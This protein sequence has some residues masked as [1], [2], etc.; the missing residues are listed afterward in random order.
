VRFLPSQ[1]HVEHGVTRRALAWQPRSVVALYVV[2]ASL[3]ILVSDRVL[4]VSVGNAGLAEAIASAKGLAF[5]A[6]TAV[7]L[8]LL[9]RRLGR[10]T[11]TR[12]VLPTTMF[13]SAGFGIAIA[14]AGSNRLVA[15]NRAFA[16]ARGRRRGDFEGWPVAR[17]F[18]EDREGELRRLIESLDEGEHGVLESENLRADGSRFPVRVDA[19]VVPDAA[20]D[21]RYCVAFVFDLSQ[22][23]K[24]EQA[25]ADSERRYR[26]LFDHSPIGKLVCDGER[27]VMANE[28]ASDMFRAS[29]PGQLVGHSLLELVPEARRGVVLER[30]ERFR[31]TGEP[32]PLQ[33]DRAL[34]L[35]GQ[36]IDVEFM[37]SPLLEG[38]RRLMHVILQDVSE[39]SALEREIIEISTA[40]QA[41]IGREIH[42]GI[43]QQLLATDLMVLGLERRMARDG[44]DAQPLESLR[45]IA[46]QIEQ[47]LG[48][49]RALANGSAPV[50]I[51]AA[52]LQASL[53]AMAASATSTHGVPCAVEFSGDAQGMDQV[54]ATHLYR[55]AQEAVSN[56]A[57]HAQASRIDIRLEAHGPAFSLRVEDDGVGLPEADPAWGHLGLSIMRYR[58]RI[59]GA[60]LGF[61]SRPGGGTQVR[62]ERDGA[63]P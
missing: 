7:L 6:V 46:A 5:V 47:A 21:A 12:R 37:A 62:C 27:I 8:Y 36:E 11:L 23:R 59:I 44:T 3:W 13:E 25:L 53:Q 50:H 2:A 54:T 31:E 15:V 55:I 48:Q 34:R 28:R 9:L 32:V 10:E 57:K 16:E 20:G 26:D 49:A 61:L 51:D 60:S 58:A 63:T 45:Q 22:S 29:D 35:D 43:C 4:T 17:L 40:E 41:R 19:T 18:P 56:A 52:S 30:L 1:A 42:D 24:I 33:Q 39:R 14:D 38:G